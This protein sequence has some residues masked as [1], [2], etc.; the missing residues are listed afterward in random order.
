MPRTSIKESFASIKQ[1]GLNPRKIGNNTFTYKLPN[2][3]EITRLH[4]TDIAERFPDGRLKLMSGGWQTVT[5]KDRLNALLPSGYRLFSVKGIWTIS[6]TIG[7]GA[8]RT[9]ES[10]P[11]FE[12]M[13]IPD[14]FE[15]PKDKAKAERT[16]QQALDLK[17]RIKKFVCEAIPDSG[18]LP[19]PSSGDCWF[20]LMFDVEPE[21]TRETNGLTKID[22]RNRSNDHLE[23]HIQEGYLPG[24]L[25]RN[26]LR[27]AG[28]GETGIA[29]TFNGY[30]RD[31]KDVRRRVQRYLQR[32]LG[33][34]FR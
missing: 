6:R 24:A 1:D 3:S 4:Y 25:I 21:A 20:C 9:A 30:F 18:P 19:V 28:M 7:D 11:F 22:P 8:E 32:R 23:S 15:S 16:E 12:G 17:R 2:G 13:I 14:A 27:A 10:I 34:T 26:A 29:M 31:N 33:A 5:T